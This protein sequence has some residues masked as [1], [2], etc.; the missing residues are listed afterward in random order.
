MKRA[1]FANANLQ[2]ANMEG[3]FLKGCN[4][5]EA[6]LRGTNLKGASLEDAYFGNAKYDKET[7]WPD[8]FDPVTAGAKL[9]K[10]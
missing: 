10:E 6:D 2:K 8:G 1:C 7:I 4:F 9:I 3:T 5:D